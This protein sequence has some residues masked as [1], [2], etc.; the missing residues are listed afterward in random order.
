MLYKLDAMFV[1]NTIIIYN[2]N[3]NILYDILGK[4]TSSWM[5]SQNLNYVFSNFDV[6]KLEN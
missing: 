3:N 4:V 2:N 6:S 1:F 5:Y